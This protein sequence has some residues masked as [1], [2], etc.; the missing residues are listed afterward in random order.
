MAFMGFFFLHILLYIK[1]ETYTNFG[2]T[3]ALHIIYPLERC[4]VLYL[5]LR[6]AVTPQ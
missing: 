5:S 6:A 4:L 3:S 1:K 2:A